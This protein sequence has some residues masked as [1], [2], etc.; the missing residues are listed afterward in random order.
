MIESEYLAIIAVN[1]ATTL[2]Q[3]GRWTLL[4]SSCVSEAFVIKE[5][6][7]LIPAYR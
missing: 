1:I 2:A 6:T 7:N 5:L 4:T 3:G